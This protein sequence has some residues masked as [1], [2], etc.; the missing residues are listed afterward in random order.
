[1]NEQG[2]ALE[3]SLS[4]P[5]IGRESV[6]IEVVLGE[7]GRFEVE[8]VSKAPVEIKDVRVEKG[9]GRATIVRKVEPM[10][11]EELTNARDE[12][13]E[14]H[15]GNAAMQKARRDAEKAKPEEMARFLYNQ[16]FGDFRD[17]SEENLRS[18]YARARPF[19]GKAELLRK[20]L[21][22][23]AE[24]H[25]RRF[26]T[27]EKKAWDAMKAGE[28]YAYYNRVLL[29]EIAEE[30]LN[31]CGMDF[32][33]STRDAADKVVPMFLAL[34]AWMTA[35]DSAEG[36]AAKDGVTGPA[37]AVIH[38]A[39]SVDL[40]LRNY[41]ETESAD[42]NSQWFNAQRV[43]CRALGV[44]SIRVEGTLDPDKGDS[45][46]WWI[47]E[48]WDPTSVQF[49]TST[50][51]GVLFDPPKVEEGAAR[52]RIAAGKKAARY[53]FEMRVEKGGDLKVVVHESYI[54][55]ESKFPY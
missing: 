53:W 51:D 26:T 18:I 20:Q 8:L 25:P 28:L 11:R 48:K 2:H 39:L 32:D 3:A 23:A 6:N 19:E 50:E 13:L 31:R 45:V 9:V 54:P 33:R 1:L 4:F 12:R 42:P 49:T 41:S 55:A 27:Q 47:L 46:D 34:H 5:M 52:L 40:R 16:G 15:A 14:E 24:A 37:A 38:K 22:E 29:T 35:D 36:K 43:A 44:G 10:S 21:K 7:P 30:H 17:E